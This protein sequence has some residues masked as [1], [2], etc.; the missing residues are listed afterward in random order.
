MIAKLQTDDDRRA[1]L[2]RSRLV[3]EQ[4][5]LETER[6]QLRGQ[7][8]GAAYAGSAW[9]GL[10]VSELKIRLEAVERTLREVLAGIRRLDAE[11]QP[12]SMLSRPP[13]V[14]GG[15]LQVGVPAVRIKRR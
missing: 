15:V 10:P 7:F 9:P 5:Q 14:L 6:N 1:A 4:Q 3:G 8:R 11:G 2:K 12:P 13:P